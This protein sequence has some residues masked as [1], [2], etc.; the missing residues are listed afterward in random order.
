MGIG[1]TFTAGADNTSETYSGPISG[2]SATLVKVGSGAWTV[3][4]TSTMSGQVQVG[5]GT[6]FVDGT[7]GKSSCVVSNGATLGGM[8]TVGPLSALAGSTITPGHGPGI[9]NCGSVTFSPTSIFTVDLTG[10]NAGTGYSQLNV[11]GTVTGNNPVLQLHMT[12]AGG[13][14]DRDT[15]INND[16]TDAVTGAFAGLPEGAILTANTGAK[17]TISYQG[18]TGNDVVL[19]QI[20]NVTAPVFGGIQALGNG[21]AALSGSGVAGENYDVQVSTNLV[22]TNWVTIATVQAA[23]NSLITFTDT[24]KAASPARFYRLKAD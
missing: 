10:T 11:T 16:L 3:S 23:T 5:A 8:G 6:L 9:L 21:Q 15:I 2:I 12:D 24:N 18:G 19:T 4:G 17:F 14:G 1:T 22:T 20:S 13:V 7:L